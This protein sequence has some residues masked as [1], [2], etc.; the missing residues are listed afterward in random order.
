MYMHTTRAIAVISHVVGWLILLSLPLLFL[1]QQPGSQQTAG[2]LLYPYYWVFNL[3]LTFLFYLHA[4]WLFPKL[5]L[6]KKYL[7]YTGALL[8]GFV[9]CGRLTGSCPVTCGQAI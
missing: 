1:T 7:A 5:Y 4:Y 2:F 8:A 6:K 3:S 9:F